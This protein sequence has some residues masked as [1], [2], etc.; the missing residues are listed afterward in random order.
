MLHL[1]KNTL[2]KNYSTSILFL[3]LLIMNAC[4]NTNTSVE[5]NNNTEE[6]ATPSPMVGNDKDEHGCIASAGY[7]WS[8]AKN[9]CVRLFE[10]ADAELYEVT[11]NASYEYF[12]AVLFNADQTQ[13]EI[14]MPNVN[15]LILNKNAAKSWSNEVYELKKDDLVYSLFENGTLVFSTK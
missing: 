8:N 5:K 6:Q 1:K 9:E 2:M 15:P 3:L 4:S 7:T 12:V 11:E 10:S 14:F 13:A